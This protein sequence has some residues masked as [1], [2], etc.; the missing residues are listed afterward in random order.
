MPKYQL[1]RRKLAV[2][3]DEILQRLEKVTRDRRHENQ[4]L[5]ADFEEQA[6]EVENDQV[7]D[8]LDEQMR[9]ELVQIEKTF[10]RMEQG[11]YG[12]CEDCGKPISAPRLEA[13]P[14]AMRCIICEEA[15]QHDPTATR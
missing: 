15:F 5:N 6:V 13:L 4:P 12:K 3:H 9:A 8:A 2:R 11:L 7:L 14:Y 10:A 1:I